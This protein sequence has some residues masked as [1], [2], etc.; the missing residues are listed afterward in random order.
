MIKILSSGLDYDKFTFPCGEL[1]VRL[2]DKYPDSRYGVHQ[3]DVEWEFERTEEIVELL[4]LVDALRHT[5]TKLRTLRIPY[6]PFGRQDRVCSQGEPLSI[7]VIAKLIN[8]C[9]AES[10]E[11]VDP[12]SDVTTAL[13]DNVFVKEQYE[14]FLTHWYDNP[15]RD[16]YLISPDAGAEK[17]VYK[18]A[19]L[20]QGCKGVVTCSK[21]RNLETGEIVGVHVNDLIDA[22]R[23]CYIV[24]DIC[25]GGRTF[26][27]IAKQLKERGVGKIVL[28]VT[29][30]FFTKGLDVFDG[31]I[32]EIY[33]R[34]GRV[35]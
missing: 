22:G 9:K 8:S 25:D 20:L 13:I 18:L 4:L 11:I 17:K 3:T 6:V 1:H 23:T 29:H 27:E 33:T 35:K 14:V 10:V 34:K 26:I 12:H 21:Q 15:E 19:S 16:Y 2:K 32:D 7:Y 31:L 30:G 28:M 5:G 24:D